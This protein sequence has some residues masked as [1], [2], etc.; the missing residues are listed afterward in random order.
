MN[1]EPALVIELPLSLLKVNRVALY[2][3]ERYEAVTIVGGGRNETFD[4]HYQNRVNEQ[5]LYSYGQANLRS[6]VGVNS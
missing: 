3:I 2:T 5:A 6:T 4:S 1:G